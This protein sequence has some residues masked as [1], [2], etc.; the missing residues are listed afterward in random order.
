[1]SVML[2]LSPKKIKS[3]LLLFIIIKKKKFPRNPDLTDLM[4]ATKSFQFGPFWPK[5]V[6]FKVPFKF[7]TLTL[8]E[9]WVKC[10]PVGR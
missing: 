5:L 8:V 3:Y 7:A 2:M 9:I 6:R 10:E 1:M 4:M